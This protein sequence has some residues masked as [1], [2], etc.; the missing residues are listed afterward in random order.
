MKSVSKSC[1]LAK[2]ASRMFEPES[3]ASE[4][5]VL[6]RSAPTKFAPCR[7]APL[8]S[9][10]ARFLIKA[11]IIIEAIAG[12]LKEGVVGATV[13]IV[14]VQLDSEINRKYDEKIGLNLMYF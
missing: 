11:P 6:V 10:F 12:H 4:R 3:F 14:V 2:F 5:S 8:K 1:V 13:E 9:A 7:Y